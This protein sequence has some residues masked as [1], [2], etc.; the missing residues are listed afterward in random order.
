MSTP[1]PQPPRRR[2]W[3]WIARGAAAAV[4]GVICIQAALAQSSDELHRT[5]AVS[6][7]LPVTLDV[8][9]SKGELQI[10]YSREGQLSIEA[11]ADSEKRPQRRIVDVALDGVRQ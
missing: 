3:Q 5:L 8:E 1:N 4:A 2:S 10:L 6:L 11:I 9:L 7:A